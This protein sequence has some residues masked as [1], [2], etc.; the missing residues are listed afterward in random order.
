[1]EYSREKILQ[2]K[3]EIKKLVAEQKSVKPQRKTE[4]FHGTRTL[5]AWKAVAQHSINRYT[6]RHKYIAY[7]FMRGKSLEQI[8]GKSKTAPNLTLV[9]KILQGYEEAVCSDAK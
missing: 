7:G 9:A 4:H 5:P 8:E 2:M 3:E 6:L 1:M